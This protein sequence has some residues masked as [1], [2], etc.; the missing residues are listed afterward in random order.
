[1]FECDGVR[2]ELLLQLGGNK[3]IG[4]LG[5]GADSYGT[6]RRWA[7]RAISR[8]LCCLTMTNT[9]QTLQIT[10]NKKQATLAL[11]DGIF[12]VKNNSRSSYRSPRINIVYSYLAAL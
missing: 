4:R 5:L 7:S 8:S 9:T 1:M 2:S 11:V 12:S 6:G 3:V 10:S